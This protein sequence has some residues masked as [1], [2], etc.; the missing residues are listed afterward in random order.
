MS[1][2]HIKTDPLRAEVSRLIEQE[3]IGAYQAR[4]IATRILDYERNLD[5]QRGLLMDSNDAPL[6]E[7]EIELAT[8]ELYGAELDMLDDWLSWR[9][10]ENGGVSKR[11][12]QVAA[13]M[14]QKLVDRSIRQLG[15]QHKAL[16]R[17]AQNSLRYLKRSSNQLVKSLKALRRA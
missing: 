12:L 15:K 5:Y 3:G 16:R 8:R 9:G 2:E 1:V 7:Q 13:R 6:T 4:E 14:K 17:E 10:F 11:D